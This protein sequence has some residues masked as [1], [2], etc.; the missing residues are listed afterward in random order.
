[1]YGNTNAIQLLKTIASVT[2]G[3]KVLLAVVIGIEIFAECLR[4]NLHQLIQ[5][6]TVQKNGLQARYS[7]KYAKLT[8]KHSNVLHHLRKFDKR[9]Y[10]FVVGILVF[11]LKA[12]RVRNMRLIVICK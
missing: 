9:R 3:E 5:L 10:H 12:V 8:P 1:M 4:T 2:L 7:L 11:P 6:L